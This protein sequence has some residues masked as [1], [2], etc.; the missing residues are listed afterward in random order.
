MINKNT[1]HKGSVLIDLII[2]LVLASLFIAMI[3][4]NT[5]LARQTFDRAKTRSDAMSTDGLLFASSTLRIGLYGNEFYQNDI[6]LGL[7]TTSRTDF[8][9][10]EPRQNG[11]DVHISSNGL[12]SV[13]FTYGNVQP[14]TP[15]L[16]KIHLPIDPNQNPTS[17]I[18]RNSIAYVSFDS[19]L[20]SDADLAMF[21]IRDD[22][23]LVLAEINTGPG[24][25]DFV[26]VGKYLYAVSPSQVGQVHIIEESGLDSLILKSRYKLALPYATAT[27]AL[28]SAIAYANDLIF[29]GT[30]K[31]SGDEFN[32][33]D[34]RNREAPDKRAGYEVDSK[35]NRIFTYLDRVYTSA[36]NQNQLLIFDIPS[37]LLTSDLSDD[38][39]PMAIFSPDGWVR[40]EG[41]AISLFENRLKF[42]RTSGGFDLANEHE[43][44][45][46]DTNSSTTFQNYQSQNQKGGV[47]DIVEDK[48]FTYFT[49]RENDKEFYVIRN[50]GGESS[51]STSEKS[52]STFSLPIIPERMT[53][54]LDKIYILAKQA[55]FIYEL[56]FKQNDQ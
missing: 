4:R 51:A 28:G 10:I 55:P 8:S 45:D 41:G 7:S 31:W 2:A 6:D 1:L 9:F 43:Y 32:I 56:N 16:R 5:S 13:S 18:V 15:V 11:Q 50:D 48:L 44:F 35:V 26:L 37:S 46:F 27:P 25:I 17:L 36:S 23:A 14:I 29:L 24:I 12:C 52:I 3:A 30:K 22:E 53:C 54:Y 19:A 20:A 34:I 49:S 39:Q 21:D 40:Q 38:L 42:G 33:L 47:Y